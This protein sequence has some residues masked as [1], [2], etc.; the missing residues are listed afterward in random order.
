MCPGLP[1][2]RL[3]G[4]Q[5]SYDTKRLR[6]EFTYCDNTTLKMLFPDLE[7]KS[8]EDTDAIAKDAYLAFTY[9]D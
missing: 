2:Y 3:S 7:C 5:G 8:W 9:M 6:M 1:L 4:R